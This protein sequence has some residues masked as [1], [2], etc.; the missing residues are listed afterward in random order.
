MNVPHANVN[1]M[2]PVGVYTGLLQCSMH[3]LLQLLLDGGVAAF[4]E[5]RMLRAYEI[6][7]APAN[8]G[9]RCTTCHKNS[10][11]RHCFKQLQLTMASPA[12]ALLKMRREVQ[13]P[14]FAVDDDTTEATH[15]GE[16]LIRGGRM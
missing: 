4:A 9:S 13:Q 10:P 2:L 11:E 15:T 12:A 14:R 1:V 16:V 3:C 5:L 8:K 6:R 7:A